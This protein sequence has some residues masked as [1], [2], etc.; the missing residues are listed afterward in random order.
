MAPIGH[1]GPLRTGPSSILSLRI[2]LCHNFHT[3]CGISYLQ[4]T[5]YFH[6]FEKTLIV[7]KDFACLKTSN[8]HHCCHYFT[9][10]TI[11]SLLFALFLVLKQEKTFMKSIHFFEKVKIEK[12]F[13]FSVYKL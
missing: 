12:Y 1:D 2:R 3:S 11:Y 6:I 13:V 7:I 5:I 9:K 10:A 8:I 4:Y